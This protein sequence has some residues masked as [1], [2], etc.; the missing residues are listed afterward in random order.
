[1]SFVCSDTV[2]AAC[3][4]AKECGI[5]SAV[6]SNL[7]WDFIYAEYLSMPEVATL[8]PELRKRYRVMVEG[9]VRDYEC[10][11]FLFRL[12]GAHPMP[13]F[14]R[15]E[16]ISWPKPP[17]PGAGRFGGRNG[18]P[19]TQVLE[20]PFVVRP[21]RR[22]RG[23]VRRELGI[24]EDKKVVLLL[25]GGLSGDVSWEP[26][27]SPRTLPPGWVCGIA[28][29]IWPSGLALPRE[30]FFRLPRDAYMP[31][32]ITAS[33]VVLGK[34]GYG[35]VSECVVLRR[36][37]I[38]VPRANFAEESYLR[39]ILEENDTCVELSQGDFCAG[40]W[41]DAIQRAD[42]LRPSFVGEA[43]GG[44]KCAQAILAFLDQ[45]I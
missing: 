30:Q 11:T 12:P 45:C 38:F 35:S 20:M 39:R 2:P 28:H 29:G 31:D 6:I 3:R 19:K 1:V 36:P 23:E 5:P 44:R 33:D 24:G 10:A 16:A 14:D 21:A 22:T 40:N 4:L 9:I 34:I 43:N 7:S 8:E 15:A 26:D 32:V 42:L 37:L 17:P 25:F 27:G 13:A 41:A 18:R